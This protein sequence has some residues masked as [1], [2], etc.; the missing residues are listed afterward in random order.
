[1]S[2][3]AQDHQGDRRGPPRQYWSNVRWTS[4]GS[5]VFANEIVPPVP[6]RATRR[7]GCSFT[8]VY[9][10]VLNRGPAGVRSPADR[11]FNA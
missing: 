9:T 11:L 7:F 6:I 3:G 5:S 10:H 8:Q 1:M 2:P 4:T